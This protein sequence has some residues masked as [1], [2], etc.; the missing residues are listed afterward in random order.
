MSAKTQ[1]AANMTEKI[2]EVI[3]GEVE[4]RNLRTDKFKESLQAG[5]GIIFTESTSTFKVRS[6]NKEDYQHWGEVM[7]NEDS[8]DSVILNN[9]TGP[10]GSFDQEVE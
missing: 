8:S 6:L 4:V 1:V 2:M 10:S 9:E 5:E 3:E 7:P